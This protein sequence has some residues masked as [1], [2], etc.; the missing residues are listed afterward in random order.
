MKNSKGILNACLIFL[1]LLLFFILFRKY[2]REG[3]V[4]TGPPIM[5]SIPS[6]PYKPSIK[7]NKNSATR[8][9]ENSDPTNEKTW[10][11]RFLNGEWCGKDGVGCNHSVPSTCICPKGWSK[12]VSSKER[13]GKANCY[14]CKEPPPPPLHVNWWRMFH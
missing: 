8:A 10:K 3:A 12:Y 5:G 9:F 13:G 14:K 4:P 6:I 11:K 7:F 1:V 2:L